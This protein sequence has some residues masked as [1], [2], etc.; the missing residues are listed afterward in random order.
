MKVFIDIVLVILYILTFC[1]ISGCLPPA[2]IITKDMPGLKSGSPLRG[3]ESKIFVVN[4][5]QDIRT[6]SDDK[7][8]MWPHKR[9]W[10]L[11][12]DPADL[13]TQAVK[14]E[15]ERNGHQTLGFVDNLKKHDFVIDG[16]V[17]KFHSNVKSAVWSIILDS[18]IG[19]KLTVM[20]VPK[21]RG[22]FVKTY[23][24]SYVFEGGP[25]PT[26]P[27]TISIREALFMVVKD[28]STDQELIEFLQ[29]SSP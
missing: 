23:Q 17:Y 4:E 7:R 5:F 20:R 6:H 18:T 12:Q 16:T 10:R 21:S 1:T 13:V 25:T 28:I 26:D 3:I 11:D 15:L 27:M 8:V 22:V 14:K 24:G 19:I 29:Q 9:T 2:V